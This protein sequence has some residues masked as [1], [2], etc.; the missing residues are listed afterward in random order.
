MS[1]ILAGR[2]VPGILTEDRERQRPGGGHLCGQDRLE[3][4]SRLR[5][6]GD[7][8]LVWVWSAVL[9]SGRL[10]LLIYGRDAA[11]RA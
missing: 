2:D 5:H 9:P 6:L 1:M 4:G 11:K 8:G 3:E 7:E 10:L